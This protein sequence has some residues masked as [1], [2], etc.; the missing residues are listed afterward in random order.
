L[1]D[2]QIMQA[3]APA[4][5][6]R[7]GGSN[8]N[9]HSIIAAD[10]PVRVRLFDVEAT[11]LSPYELPRAGV[12]VI[13]GEDYNYEGGQHLPVASVMPYL[14]GAY[15]NLVGVL[16]VDYSN[17]DAGGSQLYRPLPAPNNVN[18]LDN[19]LGRYGLE[20]PGWTVLQNFRV[21]APATGDW[22]QYTR[23]IPPGEYWVWAALSHPGTGPG[24]LYG[25]LDFV[26]GDATQ[27][28]ASL[29]TLGAFDAPGSGGA[30]RNS[31]VLLRDGG[32]APATVLIDQAQTTLRFNLGSGDLDWFVLVPVTSAP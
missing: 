25:T 31:L 3:T 30:G 19:L 8:E 14:G 16:N 7:L 26:T 28:G 6:L 17:A 12:F 29:V 27:P 24:Q 2:G 5:V 15:G 4:N 10:P 18:L 32:G 23:T 20:R 21:S 9:G 13:E 22:Q 11:D 1:G